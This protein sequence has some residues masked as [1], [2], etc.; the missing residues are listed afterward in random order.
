MEF[1]LKVQLQIFR[2]PIVLESTILFIED[3]FAETV[4]SCTRLE[5][6]LRVNFNYEYLA[7]NK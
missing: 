6:Y 1:S 3:N 4:K 5:N 2:Q 7:V